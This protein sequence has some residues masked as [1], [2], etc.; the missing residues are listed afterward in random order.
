MFTRI[1]YKAV[2]VTTKSLK[3]GIKTASNTMQ[4]TSGTT[5]DTIS[6]TSERIKM[7]KLYNS[8]GTR[9]HLFNFTKNGKIKIE[10]RVHGSNDLQFLEHIKN[11][12]YVKPQ[13]HYEG[14]L[15]TS[16]QGIE[17][18]NKLAKE[19]ISEN[20]HL[21]DGFRYCGPNAIFDSC[22]RNISRFRNGNQEIVILDRTLD[23]KLV[24]TLE[25]FNNRIKGKNLTEEQKL[26][27]LMKFV[28]EVF[29]VSKSGEQTS[30]YVATNLMKAQQVEVLLGDIINSGAGMCRHRALLTKILADEMKIKCRMVHG[31]YNGGGH[32]W[33]EII[34]K[35]DTYLFDAMHG[36]VFSIGNTSRNIVPEVLPYKITDPKNTTNLISKYFDDNSTVGILYKCVKHRSPITTSIATLTPTTNG[37]RIEP[38]FDNVLIN[39]ERINGAK[40]VFPGDYINLKDIGFQII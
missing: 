25:T 24:K 39:G 3:T 20:E 15:P 30:K 17:Q 26:D 5:S 28:D 11:G 12:E 13:I 18:S 21:I 35:T 10:Q 36:N 2:E 8:S 1:G 16:R 23:K 14:T 19:V 9:N 27:E 7:L 6:L 40:E 4:K 34:T 32:A 37:Y 29:S 31:Y 38:L 22:G 33:N